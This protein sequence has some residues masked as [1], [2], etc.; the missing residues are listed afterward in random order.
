MFNSGHT[1]LTFDIL[2]FPETTL[3]LLSSVIEPLRAT[4][5]IMGKT[6][7]EWRLMT[8]DGGPVRTTANISIPVDMAFNAGSRTNPLVVVSSYNWETHCTRTTKAA[9][10]RVAR[11]APTV[12]GVESGT[13]LM[14]EAG[15]LDNHKATIHWEDHDEFARR[16]P[17]IDI[18]SDRFVIDR[19]RLTSGGALPTLDMMLEIIRRREGYAIALEVSRSFL[20]ERDPHVRE[21]L[22]PSTSAFGIRDQ[23]LLQAIT[24]MEANLATPIRIDKIARS[25]GMSVRHLQTL[26]Q[27]SLAAPPHLHYLALRLNAARRRVIESKADFAAISEDC[28]FC[29]PSAFSR[30]YREQFGES[31]TETRRRA[32]PR[33]RPA[34]IRPAAS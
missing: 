16:Y 18:V 25:I 17:E 31:A 26:F 22:P 30:A 9:L 32:T 12:I 13:W 2:A 20:Y 24:I 3:I 11:E 8:F 4:N 5:R 6:A 23:R 15:L 1:P 29:S 34:A 28:G 27:Q 7:Y 19:H 10:A 21:L 33:G 14:A